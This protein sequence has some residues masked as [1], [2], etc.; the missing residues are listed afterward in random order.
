ML[1]IISL[2]FIVFDILNISNIEN[3][4]SGKGHAKRLMGFSSERALSSVTEKCM[5][6]SEIE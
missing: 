4:Q 1:I 5:A 6:V 3:I 2:F